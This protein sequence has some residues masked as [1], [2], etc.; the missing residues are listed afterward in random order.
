LLLVREIYHRRY[1][2][3]ICIEPS[4]IFFNSVGGISQSGLLRPM[5]GK[6]ACARGNWRPLHRCMLRAFLTHPRQP[7]FG[8]GSGLGTNVGGNI[9]TGKQNMLINGE[10]EWER[11]LG[12]LGLLMGSIIIFIRLLICLKFTID[13]YKKLI[14]DDALPWM[15]LPF[16]LLKLPQGQWG[17]PTSLGLRLLWEALCWLLFN[18]QKNRKK[19]NPKLI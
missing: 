14:K 17:T 6:V 12:E 15:I 13:S 16:C 19:F 18:I 11:V 5:R 7:F 4:S 8:F 9:I 1:N 2:C 3:N 10:I